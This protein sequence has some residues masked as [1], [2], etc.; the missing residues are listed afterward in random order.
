MFPFERNFSCEKFHDSWHLLRCSNHNIILIRRLHDG[1]GHGTSIDRY[2]L[3]YYVDTRRAR[4]FLF[5]GCIEIMKSNDVDIP[6]TSKRSI[7]FF[8]QTSQNGS[9]LVLQYLYLVLVYTHVLKNI[10]G[11]R[12]EDAWRREIRARDSKHGHNPTRT[13]TFGIQI[14]L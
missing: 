3:I 4:S 5:V 6:L 10:K 11:G 13:S 1:L 2:W 7:K 12:K 8:S 14:V 9:R